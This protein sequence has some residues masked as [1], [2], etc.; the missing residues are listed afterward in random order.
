M[1]WF[2]FGFAVATDAHLA[3]SEVILWFWKTDLWQKQTLC[4]LIPAGVVGIVLNWA[5]QRDMRDCWTSLTMLRLAAL[6]CL[7]SASMTL[8]LRIPVGQPAYDLLR[9]GVGMAA[10][11]CVFLSMLFHSRFVIYQ[12][13]EP[14]E[15]RPGRFRYRLSRFLSG[16]KA[17]ES[18][19]SVDVATPTTDP[20]ELEESSQRE[21]EVAVSNDLSEITDR[22]QSQGRHSETK[23]FDA[24]PPID[25]EQLKGL[26]KRERRK[27]R[28]QWREHQRALD[29]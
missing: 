22:T 10:H 8:N 25:K 19:A 9:I 29:E 21:V 27:L 14:P 20:N 12:S 11:L 3:A 1:I 4:W 5:L 28:K 15:L 6:L 17:D 13:A 26:S 24:S 16:K 2:L 23:R 7:L 18:E